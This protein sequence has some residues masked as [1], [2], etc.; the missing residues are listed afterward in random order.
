MEIAMSDVFV[1]PTHSITIKGQEVIVKDP[2][3]KK[4]LVML[5]DAK[6]MLVKLTNL[7]T[8][9]DATDSIGNLA[10]LLADEEVF[11]TF[12]SCASACTNKPVE[13]FLGT[14][15]EDGITLGEAAMLIDKMRTAVNWEVLKQLFRKVIPTLG[16]AQTNLQNSP[17][18]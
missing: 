14:E 18:E 5:R 11:R 17:L 13:F 2:S 9:L 15:E 4:V 3:L 7:G 16:L 6:S 8:G 10:E 12:C 1:P